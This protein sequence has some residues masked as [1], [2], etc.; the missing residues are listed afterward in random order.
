MKMGK[1]WEEKWGKKE[2]KEGRKKIEKGKEE[3]KIMRKFEGIKMNDDE[4][5]IE[6]EYEGEEKGIKNSEVKV[7]KVEKKKKRKI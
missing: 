4:G 3:M 6:E 1:N 2:G 5:S 7:M